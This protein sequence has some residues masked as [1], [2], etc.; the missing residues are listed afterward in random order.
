MEH[1]ARLRRGSALS[2]ASPPAGVRDGARIDA[3]PNVAKRACPAHP[4]RESV[5]RVGF[6]FGGRGLRVSDETAMVRVAGAGANSGFGGNAGRKSARVSRH[7]ERSSGGYGR[8]R[9]G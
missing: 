6:R 4:G 5:D 7:Y 8:T 3:G 2:L 1:T 9:D